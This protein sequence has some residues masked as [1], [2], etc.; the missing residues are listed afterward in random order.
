MM[1]DL[2][3]QAWLL[4]V[5]ARAG[6]DCSN[7]AASESSRCPQPSAAS[8]L[9]PGT[10]LPAEAWTQTAAKPAHAMA[11]RTLREA[12]IDEAS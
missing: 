2:V 7:A 10:A 6:E 8:Q 1:S 9:P 4:T 11:T 5:E 12:M 3:L